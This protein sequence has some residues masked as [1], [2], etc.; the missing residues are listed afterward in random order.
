[1]DKFKMVLKKFK[2]LWY[3]LATS[4]VFSL[5][6]FLLNVSMLILLLISGPTVLEL[7]LMMECLLLCASICLINFNS[8]TSPVQ[9]RHVQKVRRNILNDQETDRERED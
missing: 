7:L 3:I 2:G 6:W 4:P 5:A 8:I 9:Y 1:M